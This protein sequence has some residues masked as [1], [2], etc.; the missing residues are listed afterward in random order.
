MS[1][2]R[3]SMPA[4]TPRRLPRSN[5]RRRTARS[6]T[7]SASWASSRRSK[8]GLTRACSLSIN[9]ASP[10]ARVVDPSLFVTSRI[11]LNSVAVL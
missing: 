7:R 4:R 2:C 9:A 3:K 6:W 1:S 5:S 8:N 10:S 11:V